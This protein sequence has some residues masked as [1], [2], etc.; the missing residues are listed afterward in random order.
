MDEAL[1]PVTYA[2]LSQCPEMRGVLSRSTTFQSGQGSPGLWFRYWSTGPPSRSEP[3]PRW[4][5]I[6]SLMHMKLLIEREDLMDTEQ[7]DLFAANIDSLA[8]ILESD[9]K[10]PGII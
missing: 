1:I 5:H 2:F 4:R 8:R 3:F 6:S 7:S 9:P 10:T